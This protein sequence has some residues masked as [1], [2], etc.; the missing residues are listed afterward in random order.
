MATDTKALSHLAE[1]DGMLQIVGLSVSYGGVLTALRDIDLE[2]PRGGI[3]ALL[4]S[5]GAGKTTLL[6]AISRN[7]K[8]HQGRV[9]SGT[10]TFDGHDLATVKTSAVTASGLVQVPEGRRIF[11]RL[12]VEE[13][14]R[15]G[16]LRRSR[17]E[18][19]T[20]RAQVYEM[21]PRLAERS[22]QRGLLLSG[23]EQQMLA[24]GRAMMAGP[25]LLMLDEPSLGLAPLVVDQVAR[26]IK[27]INDAGTS[28]LLIEQNANM[29]LSIADQAYVLDLGRVSLQGSAASLL[30]SNEVRHLYLGHGGGAT[31]AAENAAA[32]RVDELSHK[33][34]SRWEQR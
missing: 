26:V 12:T 1:E 22:G 33:T 18:A 4:G 8:R 3:V 6:R 30:G 17:S 27:T 24:I 9:T 25:K 14:L 29:A 10:I 16:G 13:N 32:A 5:N 28:I 7:L 34:L 20:S 2:V 11:G 23:G 15:I 21:F 31:A 19:A